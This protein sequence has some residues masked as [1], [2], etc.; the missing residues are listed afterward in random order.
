MAGADDFAYFVPA[1]LRGTRTLGQSPE[2]DAAAANARRVMAEVNRP[3]DHTPRE[4][5]MLRQGNLPMPRV[6]D[7]VRDLGLSKSAEGSWEVFLRSVLFGDELGFRKGLMAKFRDDE[8]PAGLRRAIYQRA[9]AFRRQNLVEVVGLGKVPLRKAGPFIGPRG[10]KW[11]DAKHKIPWDPSKHSSGQLGLFGSKPKPKPEPE[12]RGQAGYEDRRE[13]KQERKEQRASRLEAEAASREKGAR[14]ISEHIPMGQPILVGHHSEKRHRRDIKRIQEGSRRAHEATVEAKRIRTQL[15]HPSTAVSADDPEAVVKLKE[16]IGKLEKERDLKKK[17]NRL[18]RKKGMTAETLAS[19]IGIKV[20]TAAQLMEPDYAGR[21]GIPAYELTNLGA[22]I[23]RIKGRIEDLKQEASTPAGEAVEGR[24]WGIHED[25]EDNRIHVTFDAKPSKEITRKM[26]S[27]GFKWSPTREAWVR[28]L[29]NA[30][31]YAAERVAADLGQM[32]GETKMPDIKHMVPRVGSQ[33]AESAPSKFRYG[34]QFRPPGMGATPK[35]E[36][37]VEKHGDFRHGVISYDR[38]L[39]PEEVKSYELTP[40]L[41]TQALGE[42]V[43][44]AVGKLLSEYPDEVRELAEEDPRHFAAMARQALADQEPGHLPDIDKMVEAI[45]QRVVAK[46]EEA[47][48][49]TLAQKMTRVSQLMEGEYPGLS[50]A[51]AGA[52]YRKL[53]DAQAGRPGANIDSAIAE[54]ETLLAKA[55]ARGGKYHR[56][57][58]KPGGGFQYFYDEDKYR[59]H[60][61]AHLSGEEVTHARVR[62]GIEKELEA[63]GEGGCSLKRLHPLV[64]KHGR[65][66]VAAVLKKDCAAGGSLVYKKK[67]LHRAEKKNEKP[68]ETKRKK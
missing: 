5:L 39:T 3:P 54:A 1:Q 42:R 43:D 50:E 35:G 41:S 15:A 53:S 60:K 68:T 12:H 34:M 45:R 38:P 55:E 57:A 51:E 20:T 59:S 37:T 65:N 29:N 49:K 63:D 11:A 48:P 24:G 17:V 52:L 33:A 8:T 28:Q 10:G 14:E 2:R 47:Q 32:T 7:V 9:A 67:R 26:R 6:R 16:K 13:A 64:K 18:V 30:G 56:R 66:A 19:E 61:V 40:I 36:F 22:N 25:L 44:V 23:R 27:H 21:R 4:V 62:N 31:R 58:A 46:P